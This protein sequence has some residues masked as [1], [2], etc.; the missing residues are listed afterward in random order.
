M[1]LSPWMVPDLFGMGSRDEPLGDITPTQLT[2]P[3]TTVASPM[4]SVSRAR[5]AVQSRAACSQWLSVV[6]SLESE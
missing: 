4:L 5:V 1:F 3:I 2:N 6:M